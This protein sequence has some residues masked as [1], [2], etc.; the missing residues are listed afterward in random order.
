MNM[1]LQ[2]TG[3]IYNTTIWQIKDIKQKWLI[4]DR[5]SFWVRNCH[6]GF[7]PVRYPKDIY[8]CFLEFLLS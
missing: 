5:R 3:M 8:I 7:F 6:S 2:A 1:T 4:N